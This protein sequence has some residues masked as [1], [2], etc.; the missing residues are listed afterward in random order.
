[1]KKREGA[2]KYTAGRRPFTVAGYERKD[3]RFDIWIRYGEHRQR[4]TDPIRDDRGQIVPALEAEAINLIAKAQTA[5]KEGRLAPGKDL[6]V[7][8]VQKGPVTLRQ[9]FDGALAITDTGMYLVES[10]QWADMRTLAADICGILGADREVE[11]IRSDDGKKLW[12]GIARKVAARKTRLIRNR[13]RTRAIPWGGHR[14]AVRA[15]DLLFRMLRHYYSEKMLPPPRPPFKWMERLDNDWADIVGKAPAVANPRHSQAEVAKMLAGLKDADPRLALLLEL[16][17]ETRLGQARRCT[18]R[19]LNLASGVGVLGHGEL[20]IEGSR[21][22]KG[23]VIDITREQRQLIDR[24]LKEGYLRNFEDWYQMGRIK[25]YPLF[26]KG[27]FVKGIAS[28]RQL[29]PVTRDGLRGWFQD[30]ESKLRIPHMP[31]RGWYGVRRQAADLAEDATTDT[32]ALNLLTGHSDERMRRRY[33]D[34]DNPEV[35][36]LAVET[37]LSIRK[38]VQSVPKVAPKKKNSVQVRRRKRP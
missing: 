12:V 4:L 17:A 13:G 8:P 25:D 29:A 24:T 36:R 28:E 27:R 37:R 18:R 35:R 19:D 7:T 15:V 22:K 26:P 6:E 5:L 14:M 32:R 30:Y 34:R 21:K 1:M 20:T 10:Q 9:A 31:G 23:T 38:S 2:W 33:Q 11:S 16:A 3:R